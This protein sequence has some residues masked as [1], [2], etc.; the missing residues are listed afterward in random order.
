MLNV[1]VENQ[2]RPGESS[3]LVES[4]SVA[5][6][7]PPPRDIS[8][9]RPGSAFVRCTSVPGAQSSS[10]VTPGTS[11][12]RSCAEDSMGGNCHLVVK[13]TF[14]MC[15]SL[16][17]DSSSACN[18][19]ENESCTINLTL[20]N[21]RLILSW[22]VNNK[23]IPPTRYTFWYTIMSKP[24]DPKVFENCVNITESSC[25]LT[26]EWVD[27]IENYIPIIVIYRGD[28]M[29][30]CCVD[31][32]SATSFRIEPP[33]FKVVGFTDHI[34]VT[35]EF[36]PV[37]PMIYGES[38]WE[39][40]N[41]VSFVI[42]EQAGKS[43]KM[44]RPK[45]KNVTG[46]F[47]HVLPDLLP[48]T[49]YCVSVYF[50]V[51][52]ENDIVKSPFKCTFLQ[53]GQESEAF[54][55]RK[56]TTKMIG[57]L[58]AA[59]IIM[60]KR[61][62]YIC[63]KNNFP[64]ALNFHNFLSW[65]FPEMP[66]SETVDSVE[67][68][69]RNKKKRVWNYDY[70]D[71]SDSDNEEIPKASATGYTMHGLMGKLLNQASDTSANPQESHLGEDSTAEESDEAVAGAGAEP[72]LTEAEAGPGFRP[73]ES[74]GGLYEK[75]ESVF[76][77][78]FPGDDSSSVD[79]PGDKVTFNVNL[80]SVFLRV[81][82]DDSEEASEVLSLAEDMVHLDDSPHRTESGLLLAGGDKTQ[83]PQPS[84]SSQGLWTE[85]E[86]SEKTDSSDSDADAGDGYIM[87]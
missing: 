36:P 34:N 64:K 56:A 26:D 20:Q 14:K 70:G 43:V 65:I 84:F 44:H 12:R 24:E 7:R 71:E 52:N 15:V 49:N 38:I 67:I 55:R 6:Q 69:H 4:L 66:P 11:V 54:R 87:R 78:T 57:S 2:D 19:Y 31:S 42:E 82:H 80:N 68:I 16:Q 13:G 85:D 10:E 62:G 25:D 83:L 32:I 33:E 29:T 58:Q 63:L 21:F 47:T 9:F 79:G 1:F 77:D 8:G 53:P 5:V 45:V 41:Y 30:S 73:S 27:S 17:F 40:P 51:E 39:L 35:V 37:L 60:L 81:L 18:G 48:K 75:G 59:T 46:N 28:S 22:E 86:S 3:G 61:I 72:E 74:P 23:S 76:Q 50:E